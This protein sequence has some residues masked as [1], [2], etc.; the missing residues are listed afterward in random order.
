MK[1]ALYVIASLAATCSAQQADVISSAPRYRI[2]EAPTIS[3]EELQQRSQSKARG[4]FVDAKAAAHRG[5]HARA[6][7]LFEKALKVDPL[8]ADARNDLAV[9]LIIVGEA[10]DAIDELRQLIQLDPHLMMAYTNLAAIFCDQKKYTEAEEVGRRA[11]SIDP[12][13]TK[14]SLLLAIAL[15]GQGK[16]GSETQNVLETAA[17]S[18]PAAIKLLKEWYGSS[19]IA[20]KR[21]P[22]PH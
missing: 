19:E 4:I 1:F 20:D 10:E 13:S 5:D 6:I 17:R 8:F 18:N 21:A 2:A 11:L 22:D 7:K 16:R 12:N 14:A 15:Y 9:E 3:V